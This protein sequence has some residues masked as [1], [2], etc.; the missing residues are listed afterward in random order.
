M[1]D[2]PG[3]NVALE[4][5]DAIAWITL[6]RPERKN[7]F[8][9]PMWADFLAV[10]DRVLADR[11]VRV[12]VLSGAGDN[13]TAGADVALMEGEWDGGDAGDHPFAGVMT[14]LT[15]TFDK[16]IIA[17]VDGVAI[18]FGLTV[19]LHCDFVYVSD[20]AR[21]RAPFVRL[22][23][24]PEAASSF[25]LPEILGTRNA[26]EL[27]YTADFIDGARAVELGIAN[28]SVAPEELLPTALATATRIA[29]NP[30]GAVRATK[31][32]LLETR[33]DQVLA[34]IERE[35][36]AFAKRMGTPENVEALTAFWEKRPP[37]FSNL[38]DE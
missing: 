30:P 29:E 23:V 1:P 14:H 35:N 5:K 27:L 28:V 37:D 17:A 9:N 4:V 25:L 36:T 16:P 13:F 26:A 34:A 7:A 10:L 12:V 32:L 11:S 22:G 18:G 24:V 3:S 33:R 19:L 6:D 31:R 21:L 2:M 20:R 15:Q 38:P 8:T